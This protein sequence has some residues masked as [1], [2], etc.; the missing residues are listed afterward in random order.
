MDKIY[1]RKTQLGG[2]PKKKKNEKNRKRN[3]IMNFRVSPAEKEAIEARIAMTGLSKSDFFI[4]SCMY[5]KILVHGNI[6][7]FT[8]IKN[9]M[10]DI[11]TDIDRN[12]KL[13]DLDEEK[14]MCLKTILEILDSRFGKEK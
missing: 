6:R 4:E 8:E 14:A 13:E 5:Q 12:P 11:A 7:T 10:E 3:V 9:R 1:R 2:T